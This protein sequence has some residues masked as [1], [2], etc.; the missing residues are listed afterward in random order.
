MNY[1]PFFGQSLFPAEI[2]LL[3]KLNEKAGSSFWCNVGL[4]EI[5]LTGLLVEITRYLI[6]SSGQ[7]QFA[8]NCDF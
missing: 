7:V 1:S 6:F 4:T 5:S 8:V 3:L 2:T